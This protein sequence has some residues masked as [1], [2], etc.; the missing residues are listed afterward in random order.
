[1]INIIIQFDYKK[2]KKNKK[3]KYKMNSQNDKKS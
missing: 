2:E 1:M 3:N